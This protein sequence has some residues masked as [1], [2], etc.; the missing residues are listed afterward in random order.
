MALQLPPFYNSANVVNDTR[1]INYGGLHQAALD[2]RREHNIGSWTKDR[3]KTGLLLIDMQNTFCHPNGELFVGGMS[4]TAAVDDAIRVVEFIYRNLDRISQIDTTLDTH[5]IYA[6]FH[7]TFL[8]DQDGMPPAPFT[9]VTTADVKSGKWMPN[10]FAATALGVSYRVLVNHLLDYTSKL[11]AA[12][13]YSLTIWPYHGMIG[14]KGHAL[15]SGL[16]E[17][18]NFHGLVR[19]AQPGIHI[20]GTHPLVENYSIL[21]PEVTQLFDG[22]PIQRNADI[23]QQLQSLDTV[24]ITGQAKSHCVAWTIADFLDDILKRDP[25]LAKKVYILEDGTSSIVVKDPAT[26]AV[27]Y[28][29][30]PDADAAFDRFRNAGMHVVQTST[31]MEDWPDI[32]L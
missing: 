21:G 11:E 32:E 28:D 14:D 30:G 7:P 26:G 17:A 8:V 1:W 13:R 3:R 24:I 2:W 19:G 27:I 20:K 16:A 12:G 10:P 6:V 31:P 5:R 25:S 22:S 18:A 15:V 29:Y 9:T 23:L 4:G